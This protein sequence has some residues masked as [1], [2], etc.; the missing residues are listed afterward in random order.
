MEFKIK[1]E[2]VC[3][4]SK[5]MAESFLCVNCQYLKFNQYLLECGHYLCDKC[6]KTIKECPVHNIKI[7]P[8]I[9]YIIIFRIK[10][11]VNISIFCGNIFCL[12]HCIPTKCYN[13][14][15]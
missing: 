6:L 12:S 13:I 3:F 7:I 14:F 10:L 8:H 2:N 15:F 9:S 11:H 4:E 1:L 5:A